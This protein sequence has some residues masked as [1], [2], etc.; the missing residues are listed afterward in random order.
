MLIFN[1]FF[2]S[3]KL[4]ETLQYHPS[5]LNAQR[6]SFEAFTFVGAEDSIAYLQC[7]VV[8]CD[9]QD[10]N[11]R[12]NAGC[13]PVARRRRAPLIISAKHTETGK[14]RSGPILITHKKLHR[15]RREVQTVDHGLAKNE[16]MPKVFN[17]SG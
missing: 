10:E 5:S 8:I 4:D 16:V 1:R 6:L 15:P 14:L 12:C 11:S 7:D 9:A 3:C 13:L 2:L 17:K